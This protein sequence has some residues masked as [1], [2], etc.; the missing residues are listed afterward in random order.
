[1]II[2]SGN[3]KKFRVK[4]DLLLREVAGQSVLIPVGEI[5]EKLNGMIT[6]NETFRFI[7]E[8]FKEP[9]TIEEVLEKTLEEYD[10]DA[11]VIRQDIQNF[12][13]E[14]LKYNFMIEER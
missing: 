10:G 8:Q 1:M 4:G 3:E 9:H 11:E 13:A 5:S 14:S 7:W 2:I 6:L 12:V